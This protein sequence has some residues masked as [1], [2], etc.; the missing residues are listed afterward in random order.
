[1]DDA[2]R[3]FFKITRRTVLEIDTDELTSSD[4]VQIRKIL[5]QK[6]RGFKLRIWRKWRGL[7]IGLTILDGSKVKK[8]KQY[9]LMQYATEDLKAEME[10]RQ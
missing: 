6:S 8:P 10:A 4:W 7:G 5:A 1:M 9:E 3:G 2:L